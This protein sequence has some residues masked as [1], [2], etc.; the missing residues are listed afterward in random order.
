MQEERLEAGWGHTRKGPRRPAREFRFDL[1]R[2]EEPLNFS[3]LI[4]V[5]LE[6]K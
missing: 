1:T 6:R 5:G 4:K 2:Y 3:N